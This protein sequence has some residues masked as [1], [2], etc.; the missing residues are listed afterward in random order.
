MVGRPMIQ[1]DP[2]CYF[3]TFSATDF[4]VG[5]NNFMIRFSEP[6]PSYIE[7]T[8]SCCWGRDALSLTMWLSIKRLP[9][10]LFT[11]RRR[12]YFDPDIVLRILPDGNITFFFKGE[13]ARLVRII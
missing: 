7:T 8:Y 4:L 6:F 9:A 13:N 12:A 2:A 11:L 3:S 1:V 10:T 5:L